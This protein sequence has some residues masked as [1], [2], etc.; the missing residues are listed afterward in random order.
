MLLHIWY[1]KCFIT[2]KSKAKSHFPRLIA[3]KISVNTDWCDAC[4]ELVHIWTRW[5][6]FG[7]G[8]FSGTGSRDDMSL[9]G[10]CKIYDFPYFP[11]KLNPRVSEPQLNLTQNR[12]RLLHQTRYS[13]GSW[14]EFGGHEST[15]MKCE[16]KDELSENLQWFI[17]CVIQKQSKSFATT[18][19]L[20]KWTLVDKCS[21]HANH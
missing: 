4:E 3:T 15:V 16:P 6:L 12:A 2:V 13:L 10:A 5:E 19:R 1:Q 18:K 21:Q 17:V 11:L 20:R 7:A 9:V 8:N 14:E